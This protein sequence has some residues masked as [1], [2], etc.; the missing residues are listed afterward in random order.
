MTTEREVVTQRET[1]AETEAAQQIE[2]ACNQIINLR[3]RPLLVLY[4]PGPYGQMIEN[5][6]RDC[7]QAFRSSGIIAEKPLPNCD[8][9]IHTFG[10][11][12]TAAYRLGQAIRDFG[13]QIVYLVP[14]YAY[15]AGTLLCFSGN[16]IRF[17]H[18]AGLSP[19]DITMV[20]QDRRATEEEVELTS[21]D[22]FM[23][24]AR[25]GQKQIQQVLSDTV[26]ES[27]CATIG[28]DLLCRM[29]DQIGALKV[30]EYY[31]ARTLTGHYAEEFL[32]RYMLHGLPNAKGRRNTIIRS[33]LFRA[34]AHQYYLDFHMCVDLGLEVEEMSTTESDV[35][36]Q[37]VTIL[38][39]LARR[40]IICP[41][42]TDMVK[43]PFI[44]FYP[45]A[46]QGSGTTQTSG[47][48][49][50]SGGNPNEH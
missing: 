25:D 50:K 45:F 34:P 7:Y 30:G 21:I 43:M 37:V 32:D 10:G 26:R 20:S 3:K 22:Y 12:P 49:Q 6:V 29:V 40:E 42:V 24:F 48:T 38:D 8:V 47:S 31:R 2:Q 46:K 14:E 36:K 13:Q 41:N 19:I 35:A 18:Y 1:I 5:D 27:L 4:Y 11:D 39:D 28:S 17:G 16:Q 23:E 44:A 33:L 9:L 15:S